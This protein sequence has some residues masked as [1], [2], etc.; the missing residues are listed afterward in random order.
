MGFPQTSSYKWILDLP[1]IGIDQERSSRLFLMTF[2]SSQLSKNVVAL[3]S[4][5][6]NMDSNTYSKLSWCLIMQAQQYESA[7]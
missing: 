4:T 3:M 5:L 1:R 2:S 6:C 7:H